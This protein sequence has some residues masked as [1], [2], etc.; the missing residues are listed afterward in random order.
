MLGADG[1]VLGADGVAFGD[2]GELVAC[3]FAIAMALAAAGSAGVE[4][5]VGC[6][7]AACS[8]AGF[9]VLATD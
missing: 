3:C 9:A 8:A 4:L 1:V 6:D 2:C 7:F 5:L